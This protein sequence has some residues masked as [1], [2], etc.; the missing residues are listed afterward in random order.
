MI[1]LRDST[2]RRKFPFINMLIIAVNIYAFVTQL[3]SPNFEAVVMSFGFVP[4]QFN[5]FESASYS[6][7]F[8]SMFMHGNLIH[9]IS[10]LWFLHIFGDN[11][12]DEL[13]HFKYLLFYLAGGAAATLAQYFIDPSTSLPLIGASGAIS[14]VS[15]AYFVLHAKARVETLIPFFFIWDVVEL[16][17]RFMLGYWFVVQLLNGFASVGQ[18]GGGIAFFA[19]VGGFVFG[20]LFAKTVRLPSSTY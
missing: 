5:F 14:A 7:I 2:P 12:E 15:G 4:A 20:Y 8:T 9:L 16:P 1:P 11:V 6:S 3:T 13:G 17:A 19:H 10:N 18:T